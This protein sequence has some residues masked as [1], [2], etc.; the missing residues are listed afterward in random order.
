MGSCCS[1]LKYSDRNAVS[2]ERDVTVRNQKSFEA[3]FLPQ[4]DQPSSENSAAVNRSDICGTE[5]IK[6][7]IQSGTH[8]VAV[9]T[10]Q[11]QV[12]I[13]DVKPLPEICK[14]GDHYLARLDVYV[15]GSSLSLKR[16]SVFYIIKG[17]SCIEVKGLSGI[18]SLLNMRNI[19][20]LHP[21]CRGGDSYFANRAGFYIIYGKDNTYLHVRDMSKNGY[22]PLTASRHPLHESFR[23]GLYY[24][25]TEDHFYVLKESTEFGLVYHRT[26]D[27]R[28]NESEDVLPVSSSIVKFLGES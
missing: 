7:I 5:T 27:L 26:V 16:K 19:F 6:Y 8:Y 13:I 20:E 14:N 2:I 1:K 12:S 10:L 9:S 22:Q 24:F 25:A 15:Q 18:F 23:N 21:K 11:D 3:T 17:K 28:S 4:T